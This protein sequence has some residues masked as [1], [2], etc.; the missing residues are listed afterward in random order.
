MKEV[1]SEVAAVARLLWHVIPPDILH[2]QSIDIL[3]SLPQSIENLPSNH[4]RG[5]RFNKKVMPKR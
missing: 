3:C 5:S 1:Q 2:I 4:S